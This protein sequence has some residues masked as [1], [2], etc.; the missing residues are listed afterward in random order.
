MRI[1]FAKGGA[2]AEQFGIKDSRDCAVRA[3]ANVSSFSYPEVHKFMEDAGR[4]RNRGTPWATLHSVYMATGAK[5]AT[6][7]GSN[8]AIKACNFNAK[9]YNK[10]LTLKSF[11]NQNSTGKYIVI[12]RGHA[13]AVCDGA[14]ID[15][16]A[17]KAGKRLLCAYKFD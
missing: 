14:V 6:Y 8:T 16:F 1:P 11:I 3:L 12:V 17:N 4:K 9:H 15:L 2:T 13:L 5:E 7:Y 10:S